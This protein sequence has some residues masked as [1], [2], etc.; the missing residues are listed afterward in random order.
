MKS[1]KKK[2]NAPAKASGR[3]ARVLRRAVIVL[4]IV[5]IAY[6]VAGVLAYR[7]LPAPITILAVQRLMEGKGYE[8]R[9]RSLDRISPN[10]VYAAVAAEDAKYC[11]HHGFDYDAIGKAMKHNEKRPNHVRG[12][13]TISQ[14][15]AK[16]V[17]LWPGRGWVR[18]GAEAWYTVLIETVWGKRR[19]ME[20]Y[21]N[22][23]EWGP[24]VYGAQAASQHWFHTDADKLNASQ[25]ARLAAILPD[26]LEW[27]AAKSGPYVR[28]RTG[29]IMAAMG[30]V[31][32]QG[33]ADCVLRR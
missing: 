7:F 16:N 4:L 6:P 25:A 1:Q 8:R 5:V 12:A 13:S 9:W 2:A 24:G 29:R 10:L 17:F 31:R 3:W 14:Q 26:P 22:V 11:S 27:K 20:M 28:A 18:K 30:T 19:T 21:L 33:L 23:V 32:A 15:T